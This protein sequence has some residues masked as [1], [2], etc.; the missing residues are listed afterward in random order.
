MADTPKINASDR[1]VEAYEKINRSIDH[2]NGARQIAEGADEKADQAIETSNT[3][4][5][6]SDSTQEQLNQIVIDGDSSVEAAQARVDADGE[7]YDTL[8]DRLDTEHTSV[9]TQLAETST[10][11]KSL[12][13]NT[14]IKESDIET[15]HSLL[16]SGKGIRYAILGDSTESGVGQ[17]SA[18]NYGESTHIN[19]YSAQ[20]LF[21]L[22]MIVGDENFVPVQSSAWTITEPSFAP[23]SINFLLP[24]HILYVRDNPILDYKLKQKSPHKYDKLTV[25]YLERT[26]N[27]SP[28]F[29]IVV[30]GITTTVDTYVEPIEYGETNN[31][32]MRVRKKTIPIAAMENI[33]F[34]INNFRTADRDGSGAPTDGTAVIFGFALGEGVDF[35]NYAVSSSTLKNVSSANNIRGITT[36]ERLQKAYDF[37]ANVISMGW[38]TNDS[39][40]GVSSPEEFEQ[41]LSTRIDEIRAYNQNAVIFLTTDPSGEIGSDYENNVMYNQIV[42]KVALKKDVSL[43]DFE[44]IIGRMDRSSV[45]ADTVHPSQLG[46][47][48]LGK[49][50]ATSFKFP[51]VFKNNLMPADET[52]DIDEGKLF[53]SV[54]LS[55][56]NTTGSFVE[57]GVINVDRPSGKFN[58]KLSA[59]INLASTSD[60]I[61]SDFYIELSDYA[62]KGQSGSRLG[63]R[64]LDRK[65]ITSFGL[66]SQTQEVRS[67]VVSLEGFFKTNLAKSYQAKVYG[68]NYQIRSSSMSQMHIMFF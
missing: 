39:K 38:G 42:A 30:D 58:V 57:I 7:S 5:D 61:D 9:T 56:S 66:D 67:A 23:N 28:L 34:T 15:L 8:K 31:V 54:A 52:A 51:F 26:N 68:K 13:D 6:K 22:S 59:Q 37:G 19:A 65:F 14:R 33:N 27:V 32:N 11:I 21:A 48:V 4:N 50:L 44:Y 18:T 55:G 24:K 29:D 12:S 49:A 41:A 62:G 63:T 16:K 17:V 36:D 53:E 43:I 10:Q 40:S 64:T 25:Y 47:T 2:A 60:I 20:D 46:Y 35:M 3:A 45:I 1:S